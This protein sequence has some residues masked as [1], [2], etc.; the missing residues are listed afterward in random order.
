MGTGGSRAALRP[1]A[2]P[3]CHLQLPLHMEGWRLP[4]APPRAPCHFPP[5]QGLRGVVLVF[6]TRPPSLNSALNPQS[7]PTPAASTRPFTSP[8]ALGRQQKPK[9]R[10]GP[11]GGGQGDRPPAARFN[12]VQQGDAG[13]GAVVGAGRLN[14]VPCSIGQ[15]AAGQD[16]GGHRVQQQ[17]LVVVVVVRVVPVPT[18]RHWAGEGRPRARRR[19]PPPPAPGRRGVAAAA[20]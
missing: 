6:C 19:R 9:L 7:C 12:A 2:L 20:F 11:E 3:P 18:T 10:P 15:Q 13:R 5:P 8:S 16:K 17:G 4:P 1:A 14:V